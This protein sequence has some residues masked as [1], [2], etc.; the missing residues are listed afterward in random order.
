M[1]S[2]CWAQPYF[3]GDGGRGIRLG[4]L[5]PEGQGLSAD[6]VHLP[7]LAQGVLVAN[8]SKY[9]AISVL[10]RIALDRV[11]AETLDL[12]YEDN[13]DIVRLGHVAQVGYMLTGRLIRTTAGFTLQINITDTTPNARTLTSTSIVSTVTQ[14]EDQ[15]AIQRASLDLLLNLWGVS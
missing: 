11:I 2:L 13:L 6:Q 7:T 9:S 12:T 1:S 14:L 8:I 15:T 5:V 4:I 10:D 3:T